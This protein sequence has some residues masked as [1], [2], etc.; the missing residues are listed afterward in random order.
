[1]ILSTSALP[2]F[3]L[4]FTCAVGAA[5]AGSSEGDRPD[6][7]K[8]GPRA[9]GPNAAR[10]NT[11]PL[12]HE[13]DLE[14][15][16][17]EVWRIFTTDEGYKTLG[18]AQA[19]IDLRVGGKMLTHYDPAG[20]LGDEGTIENTIL[21][22]EPMR[23][24]AFQ[25]TRPPKGF[26]FMGAYSSTWSVVTMQDAGNGQTHL[27][28]AGLGYTE[29]PESQKMRA[30]F[31]QGNAWVMRKL[32]GSFAASGAEGAAGT[33]TRTEAK[34]TA[35]PDGSSAAPADP[36]APIVIESLVDAMTSEVWHCWTT[37]EGMR[38]F[39]AGALIELRIGGPFEIYFD[40]QAIPGERGSEGCRIL[41]YQPQ[42]M[43]S[44]S[45][46]APPQFGPLRD[47]RTWV[48]LRFEPHGG[49]QTRVVLEHLGF[50]DQAAADPARRE[51]WKEVRAYFSAAWP[52]VVQALQA[53]F[54][55]AA[56]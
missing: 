41:S 42:S 24:I 49:H 55:P 29:D 15:P 54:A 56:D 38:S 2:A 34:G 51:D 26:P 14:A 47:Q 10:P 31:E 18:V 44:F 16:V 48:V 22:Y 46:N 12:V 28:L 53:H 30:F 3:L 11:D 39:L 52:Q 17:E 45:W 21:A 40:D 13:V 1:M 23:M 5:L 33:T 20:V 32:Q 27:R 4:L 19:R 6:P 25:I 35:D 37:S 7:A 9:D 50:A 36:L 8:P 43:L